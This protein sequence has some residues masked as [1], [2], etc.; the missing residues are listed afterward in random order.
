MGV[1]PYSTDLPFGLGGAEL[2]AINAENNL[3]HGL[4]NVKSATWFFIPSP[5]SPRGLSSHDINVVWAHLPYF[6]LNNEPVYRG[7]F[8]DPNCHRLV[9]K[10]IVQSEWHKKDFVTNFKID[11]RKIFVIPNTCDTS[12]FVPGNK[13]LDRPKILFSSHPR[14]GL[15]ILNEALH[16]MEE[17][18]FDVDVY[19]VNAHE[20]KW[21]EVHPKITLKE[22]VH[23]QEYATIVSNADILAYPCING[24]TFCMTAVEALACGLRVVTTDSGALP[25]VVGKYGHIVEQPE[26]D[27]YNHELAKRFAKAL[28]K[29]IRDYRSGKFNPT[30]QIKYVKKTYS[31]E[32]NRKYWVKLNKKLGKQ[33]PPA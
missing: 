12:L 20:F 31:N 18:E 22:R 16:Y 30:K 33:N 17:T 7:L 15:S 25:D 29:E 4:D 32:A 19:M 14:R 27:Q 24:E 2:A 3:I 9:T 10:Y 13:N 21:F 1:F 28:D 8:A 6:Y 26:V 11:E 23:Q 5:D